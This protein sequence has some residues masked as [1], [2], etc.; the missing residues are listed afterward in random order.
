MNKHCLIR[1]SFNFCVYVSPSVMSDSLRP[2][3]LTHQASLSMEFSRQEHWSGLPLPSPEDLPNPGI[4]PWSPA[5]QEGSL[6]FELQGSPL[7]VYSLPVGESNS[8]LPHDRCSNH[9]SIV[10]QLSSNKKVNYPPIKA[11]LFQ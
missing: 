2:Y 9:H 4:E 8:H 6:L 11:M 3:K 5:S 7:N 1:S 10:K